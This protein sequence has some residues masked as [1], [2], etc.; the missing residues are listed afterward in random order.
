MQIV[1]RVNPPVGRQQLAQFQVTL[2][3]ASQ[4]GLIPNIGDRIMCGGISCLVKERTF[5]FHPGN[6]YQT[7]IDFST[8]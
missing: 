3:D 8:E 4:S 2:T 7:E 1:L 5:T 6:D